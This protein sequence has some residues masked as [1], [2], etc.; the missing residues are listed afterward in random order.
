MIAAAPIAFEND[1]KWNGSVLVPLLLVDAR[2]QLF[3]V[4]PDFRT[5][6]VTPGD[7]DEIKWEITN[8]AELIAGTLAERQDASAIFSRWASWLM[9]QI[10]RQTANEIDDVQSPFANDALIGAIGHKLN[11][12]VLPQAAP[13]QRA[14]MGGVVLP[15][16]IGFVCLQRTYTGSRLDELRG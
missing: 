10:L 7:L 8:T 5:L 9:R 11:N 16:R 4:R 15:L 1:G 3:H 12:R 2:N 14:L 13:D 6:D